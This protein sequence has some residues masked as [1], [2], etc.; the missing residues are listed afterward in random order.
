[1]FLDAWRKEAKDQQA[2][3]MKRMI[4]FC[5]DNL[6]QIGVITQ[7]KVQK[8]LLHLLICENLFKSLSPK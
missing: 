8:N 7:I 6:P 2:D 1:M 5:K 4:T 3:L